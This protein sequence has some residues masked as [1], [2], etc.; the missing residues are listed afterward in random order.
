LVVVRLDSFL[1]TSY[2]TEIVRGTS[3]ELGYA[4]SEKTSNGGMSAFTE[5][6]QVFRVETNSL[7]D[8]IFPFQFSRMFDNFL[9]RP[10]SLLTISHHR[11]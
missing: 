3:S 5:V 2:G 6:K 11:S 10:E 1:P 4:G 8:N 9:V 7:L